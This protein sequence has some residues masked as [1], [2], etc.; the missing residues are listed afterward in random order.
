MAHAAELTRLQSH[1]EALAEMR[2]VICIPDEQD[3]TWCVTYSLVRRLFQV[4]DHPEGSAKRLSFWI[5]WNAKADLQVM[6]RR[7][8]WDIDDWIPR[9]TFSSNMLEC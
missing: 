3:D 8:L 2:H 5:G 6:F 9:T 4:D 1:G 7:I